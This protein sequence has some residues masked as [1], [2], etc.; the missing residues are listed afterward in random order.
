MSVEGPTLVRSSKHSVLIY[1]EVV[2]YKD[3]LKTCH[4]EQ[5]PRQLSRRPHVEDQSG[6]AS[7]PEKLTFAYEFVSRF[8]DGQI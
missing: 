6:L 8:A 4:R 3:P 2:S 5:E 7:S 1:H